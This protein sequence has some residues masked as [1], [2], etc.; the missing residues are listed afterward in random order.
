MKPVLLISV[1]EKPSGQRSSVQRNLGG[2]LKK[3]ERV[4]WKIICGAIFIVGGTVILTLVP[5]A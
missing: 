3:L 5:R 4:T 1:D 2:F